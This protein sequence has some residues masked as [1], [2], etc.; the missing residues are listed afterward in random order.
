MIDDMYPPDLP[1][2]CSIGMVDRSAQ[3]PHPK[4]VPTSDP[5]WGRCTSCGDST[6]PLTAF[7]AGEGDPEEP[8]PSKK[9]KKSTSPTARTLAECRRRGWIAGVVER[10]IPFP[11][12]QG[13][14]IDL[15]GVID[16]VAIAA[17]DDELL[18]HPTI[19][20]IQATASA[21]HHAHRRDKILSEPRMIAW[22]EAGA[23]LELWSWS[24]RGRGKAKR[25]TLRVERFEVRDGVLVGIEDGA[26]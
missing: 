25:W 11:K 15:F 23:R 24:K 10:R 4:V 7:A 9:R 14:T 2:G 19:V 1:P 16:V 6:F 18:G 21:A 26:T 17:P 8:A 5:N 12:P 3:C 20:G 13:T 22:L